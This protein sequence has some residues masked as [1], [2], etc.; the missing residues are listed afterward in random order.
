LSTLKGALLGLAEA[1]RHGIVHRDFKPENV[2]VTEE[3]GS[4]L[5]DFGVAAHEGD[6]APLVGTPSYMAPEQWDGAPAGPSADIYAAAVVFYECLTG[7]R[8][9]AADDLAALAYQHLHAEPAL[10]GIDEEIRGL[11]GQGLAKDP[12]DRPGS[13]EA[14][15]A[16]L[17]ETATEAY[18]RRW[19]VRG[20]SRLAAL[21]VPFLMTR[22][23]AEPAPDAGTTLFQSAFAPATKIALTGGL[24]LATAAAVV[25]VFLIWNEGPRQDGGASPPAALATSRPP[26]PAPDPTSPPPTGSSTATPTLTSGSPSGGDPEPA[27][28]WAPDTG[29]TPAREPSRT[30]VRS[31][32]PREPTRSPTTG[33]P[34]TS[35]PATSRPAT[36]RPATSR[37][38]TSRPS[39]PVPMRTPGEEPEPTGPPTTVAPDPST[40]PPPARAQ[41]PL[42]SVSVKVSLDVPVLSGRGDG[43]LDADVG[44][45]LG[46]GLL[47]LVVVPGSVLLGRHLVVR[48]TRRPRDRGPGD[49]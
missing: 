49:E 28:T 39:R 25:S 14:F 30:P 19:D 13:A 45:G 3:G 44:L 34:T 32:P 27:A 40:A 23:L 35:R 41:E 22:P 15:L 11:V 18:G 10:D 17:E 33:R 16:E 12:A 7:H 42:I 4:K 36:S 24:V 9:F 46:T 37:P 21:T 2:I 31:D 5:V 6:Q 47:G 43:L 1:H 29:R 26:T 38:A 48:R 20:R 8:P